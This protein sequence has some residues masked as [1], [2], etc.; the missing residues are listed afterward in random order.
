[1][2]A[3][4]S[5]FDG[6]GPGATLSVLAAYGLGLGAGGA[7]IVGFGF[8]DLLVRAYAGSDFAGFW[9]APRMYLN[10]TD[11]YDPN[12]YI[13]AVA[14]LGVQSTEWKIFGY[15][16]WVVFALLPL[17]VLPVGTAA[18]VW[19]V[20]GVLSAIT[21]IWMLLKVAAP[22][23]RLI[24]A[25]AGALLLGSTPAIITFYSGQWS[26]FLV[27]ASAAMIALFIAGHHRSAGLLSAVLLMKPHLFVFTAVGLSRAAFARHRAGAVAVAVMVT[28]AIAGGTIL[29][30]PAWFWNWLLQTPD[31]AAALRTVTL[32]TAFG[33]A[34]G[35]G[36][37]VA[38]ALM[39]AGLA[40]ALAF[41]PRGNASLA[42]WTA[43]SSTAVVYAWSYDHLLLV[44]PLIIAAGVARETSVR[45]GRVVLLVG[46]TF[47][48]VGELALYQVAVARA[49]QSLN[50]LVPLAVLA[51]VIVALWPVRGPTRELSGEGPAALPVAE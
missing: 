17:G 36:T 51:L 20:G 30:R 10:G 28:L 5:R 12:V 9:A 40:A 50:A 8:L 23:S 15:P 33:E 2:R 39:L 6:T 14:Q 34:F 25:V 31:R 46:G 24:A 22:S 35:P 49:D 1:M 42:V 47:L 43:L 7:V 26:F 44:V 11:P 37:W 16:P 4:A 29:A 41:D 18:A 27:G 45:R 32:T 38:A 13:A 21:G 48:F 3:S 19:T